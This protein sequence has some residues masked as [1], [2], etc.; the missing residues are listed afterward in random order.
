LLP[1][2]SSTRAAVALALCRQTAVEAGQVPCLV[3]LLETAKLSN[4]HVNVANHVDDT[5]SPP[6]CVAARHGDVRCLLSLLDV[7]AAAV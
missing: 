2:V 7:R 1:I 4:M 3:A 5:K 6:L